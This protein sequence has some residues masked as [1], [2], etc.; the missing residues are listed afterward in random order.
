M[1]LFQYLDYPFVL[2]WPYK[3]NKLHIVNSEAAIVNTK[4]TV[5]YLEFGCGVSPKC[6]FTQKGGVVCSVSHSEEIPQINLYRLE[7]LK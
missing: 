6:F 4:T 3:E 2:A 7:E 1:Y 5:N